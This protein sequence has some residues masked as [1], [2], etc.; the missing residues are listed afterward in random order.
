MIPAGIATLIYLVSA[1]LFII[2]IKKLQSPDTARNGNMLS[3]L[4]MLIA[5]VVTLLDQQVVSYQVI[6]AGIVVGGGL[7]YW[8]ARSVKMTSMPQMVAL[9]NGF[10]GGASLLVG[11]A[12]FLK[13]D[14]L[15]VPLSLDTNI[16]IQLSTFIGAITLAGSFVAFLK[17]Q[18][19]MTGKPV[20]F[21]LQ[22]TF[23][24]AVF[25]A[26]VAVGVY[27]V[28]TP[29]QQ[30]ELYYAMAG[31]ALLLGILLVIPIGGADMPVVI[32]LLNSYSG[33]AAA[34][35]RVRHR[36]PG[37]DHRRCSGGV[38]GPDPHQD[39]VQGHE[40]LACQ[41]PLWGLRG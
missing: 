18:E 35:D 27:Q 4:G 9:L 34:H 39:H 29:G 24:A 23:N 25:L 7:G 15:G 30:I 13:A 28:M 31:L 1:A 26:I 11:G 5:I 8:M 32:A 19:L 33:I 22:K 17:L 36:Q 40:S 10:G 2:G 41:R 16:T 6:I 3:G 14:M 37:A 38:F 20:T 12:E 21:P